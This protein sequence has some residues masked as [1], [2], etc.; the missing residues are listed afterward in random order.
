MGYRMGTDKDVGRRNHASRLHR[1][2]LPLLVRTSTPNISLCG[3]C[4]NENRLLQHHL[5]RH[6]RDIRPDRL[7]VLP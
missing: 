7:L 1:Y 4:T 6:L 5:H 2:Q 3:I